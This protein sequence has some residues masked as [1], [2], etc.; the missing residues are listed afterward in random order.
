MFVASPSSGGAHRRGVIRG[1][2]VLLGL[3]LDFAH[4]RDAVGAP[5]LPVPP[6]PRRLRTWTGADR[7]LGF[8]VEDL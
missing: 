5:R 4:H 2:G 8:G 7:I 1:S 3:P 6:A